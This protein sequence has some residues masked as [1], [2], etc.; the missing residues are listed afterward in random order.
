MTPLSSMIRL[1]LIF[2]LGVFL[3]LFF[4]IGIYGPKKQSLEALRKEIQETEVKFL[5]LKQQLESAK[6]QIRE[7]EIVDI[8]SGLLNQLP[9]TDDSAVLLSNLSEEGKKMGIEFLLFN[10]LE[11]QMTGPIIE[12]PVKIQLRGTFPQTIEFFRYLSQLQRKILLSNIE[13]T[14]P[15]KRGEVFVISTDALIT[16]FRR[17]GD[18]P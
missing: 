9:L 12:M 17:T 15:Q 6:Q 8:P 4:Y 3:L 7:E 14:A 2:L 13:M 10:P 11:E 1:V 5:S 18:K 16:T